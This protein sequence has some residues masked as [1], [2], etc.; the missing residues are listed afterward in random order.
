MRNWIK[1]DPENIYYLISFYS[2]IGIGLIF[3]NAITG[4]LN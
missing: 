4:W 1:K 2:V 3:F